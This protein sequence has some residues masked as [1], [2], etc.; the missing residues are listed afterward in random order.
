MVQVIRVYNTEE[1]ALIAAADNTG[2]IVSK[3]Y[4]Y[5]IDANEPVS[6][7]HID[8]DD[9]EDNSTEKANIQIIKN[10][11]PTFYTVVEHIYTEAKRYFPLIRT[12]S[13]D[14]YISK[15]YTNDGGGASS[16]NDFVVLE[17]FTMS[18]LSHF[19][20]NQF[21]QVSMEKLYSLE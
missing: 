6:E 8:W 15:W 17:P 3:K 21:S 18:A 11:S 9:G 2:M 20:N 1:N 13:I 16:D 19:G 7:F 12:K 4:Y 14:G 5:R 10:K